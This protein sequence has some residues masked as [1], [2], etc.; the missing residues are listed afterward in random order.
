MKRVLLFLIALFLLFLILNWKDLIYGFGQL[1]GQLKV[2][3]NAIPIDSALNS[4]DFPDSLKTN[5]GEIS[6]IV[7]Y[8]NEE[9]GLVK[10]SNYSRVYN[11]EGKEILWNVSACPEFELKPYEWSFFLVGTFPYKGYFDYEK[12]L[13]EEKKFKEL[14][15]DTRVRSVS[16]W[17]TLGFFNDP[18]L[19]NMLLKDPG[20]LAN[21]IIHEM[22]HRTVFIKNEVEMNENL[23]TFVGDYGALEYLKNKHKNDSSITR[24]YINEIFEERNFSNYV[25]EGAISLDSIYTIFDNKMDTTEMRRIKSNFIINWILGIDSLNYPRY[26]NFKKRSLENPPNNTFFMSYLR[27]NKFQ[28]QFEE[29]Y[30]NQYD[31]NLKSYIKVLIMRFEEKKNWYDF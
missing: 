5:L 7:L 22:T 6:K 3:R 10:S 2:V 20:D 31:Q 8:A 28:N 29:E 30:L 12:A 23:A 1:E 16:G 14:G 27:Y 13:K 11:Q 4:N 25:I 18:V 21:T 9:L 26:Q 17:S 19:S 24:R 15:Y